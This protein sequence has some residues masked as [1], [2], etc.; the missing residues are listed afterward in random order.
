MVVAVIECR[1]IGNIGS[2]AAFAALSF[3]V[4]LGNESNIVERF[5]AI[6]GKSR[7]NKRHADCSLFRPYG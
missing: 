1:N 4:F 7:S 5:E 2:G 3:E 6:G